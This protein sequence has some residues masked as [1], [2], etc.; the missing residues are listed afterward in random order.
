MTRTAVGPQAKQ[1]LVQDAAAVS[2][3]DRGVGGRRIETDDRTPFRIQISW[4]P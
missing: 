1:R 3:A 4:R 2:R